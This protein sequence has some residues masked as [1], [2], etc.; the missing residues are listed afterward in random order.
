MFLPLHRKGKGLFP[1]EDDGPTNT[2]VPKWRG[3]FQTVCDWTNLKADLA[4]AGPHG[5]YYRDFVKFTPEEIRKHIAVYIL[6][7][8]SPSPQLAMK[9]NTHTSSRRNQWERFYCQFNWSWRPSPASNVQSFPFF[10][11][12]SHPC[13]VKD[14]KRLS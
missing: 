8:L 3:D 13:N 4:G 6:H 12:P 2:K 7:S 14:N 10:S 1:V 5:G 9:F 11:R